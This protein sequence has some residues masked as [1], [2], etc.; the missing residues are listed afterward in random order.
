[1]KIAYFGGDWHMDCINTFLHYG[2]EIA[3]ILVNGNKPY[4]KNIRD[5]AHTNNIPVTNNKPDHK[6][7]EELVENGIN[8]LFSAEYPWLIPVPDQSV[9]TINMHP[10][11]L[12]D[13]KGPNP[14]IW[15]IKKYPQFA[16]ITFHK[17]SSEFDSG[18]IIYQK[19][20]QITENDSYETWMAKLNIEI[21]IQLSR[22]L[23]DFKNLYQS[24]SQQSGGSYW[25]KIEISHRTINWHE[26]VHEIHKLVRACGRFGAMITISGEM[27][28]I[29]HVHASQYHHQWAAGTLLREDEES[30]VM[31][32]SDGIVILMKRD[33]VERLK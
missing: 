13:G 27:M 6:L 9:K 29:N 3:H 31:A 30:Y 16:G 26:G 8:C 28:L 32:A 33:I 1:M 15:L 12:P 11:I 20:M 22:L 10:T 18:D 2:H 14:V 5:Y 7:L 17:L 4:N 19:P 24:A 25:P 21:P 23:D